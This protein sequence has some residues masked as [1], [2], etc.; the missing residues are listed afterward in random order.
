[1]LPSGPTGSVVILH[2]L[3]GLAKGCPGHLQLR[4][5]CIAQNVGKHW[6]IPLKTTL[7]KKHWQ[8]SSYRHNICDA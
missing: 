5:Y 7:A 1:M 6:Q 3:T 2:G 8:T 4:E